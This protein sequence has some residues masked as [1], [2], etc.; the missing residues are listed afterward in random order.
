MSVRDAIL[1]AS[2]KEMF[3]LAQH[4]RKHASVARAPMPSTGDL[5][6]HIWVWAN[7]DP[8]PEADAAFAEAIGATEDE[9]ADLTGG[10]G[11]DDADADVDLTED[12]A[13]AEAVLDAQDEVETSITEFAP[14][15]LST[16][17]GVDPAEDVTEVETQEDRRNRRERRALEAA[18]K[19]AEAV[20]DAMAAKKNQT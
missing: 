5:I 3:D 8:S 19:Q 20:A 12:D 1:N 4:M 9:I 15:P 11:A 6:E 2:M 14:M 7:A 16:D 10:D 18:R 13:L 17:A